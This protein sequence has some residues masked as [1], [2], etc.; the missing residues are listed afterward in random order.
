MRTYDI[1]LTISPDLVVWPSDPQV[2]FTRTAKI[3]EG[4]NANVTHLKFSAH[5]GTHVD[6]PYHFVDD[7]ETVDNLSLDLLVGRAYV[8]HL[9]EADLITLEMLKNSSI[10]PRT[11]RVLFRT[12]N[13]EIWNSN[14]T[15]FQKDFVK[16][17]PMLKT[18]L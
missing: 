14:S 16:I 4:A 9:P 6:A 12:K 8:L 18:Q 13:S 11:K 10:P 15:I 5:T 1:T 7:G 2:E 3:S 17:Y